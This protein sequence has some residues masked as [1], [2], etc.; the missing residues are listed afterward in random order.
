MIRIRSLNVQAG[1]FSLTSINLSIE[2]GEFFVLMGPTGAGKTVLL[3]AIAG[4]IPIRSGNVWVGKR[5]VTHLPPERRGIGIVY[6]DNTLFPHLSVY[7]NVVYGLRYHK[8]EAAQSESR[9]KSLVDELDLAP[10]MDRGTQNLSGGEIQR[11]SLARALSIE[12]R[13]PREEP[14]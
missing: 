6:Q 5:E 2:P 7:E 9:L 12:P 8:Q 3:E 13:P 10:L 4:L 1:E 14:A 11:V